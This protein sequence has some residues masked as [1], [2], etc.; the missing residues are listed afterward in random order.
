[1]LTRGREIR[2]KFLLDEPV[3]KQ[4]VQLHLLHRRLRELLLHPPHSHE[5]RIVNLLES[6]FLVNKL[7]LALVP[8]H[9]QL[10]A[11]AKYSSSK[12]IGG[13]GCN[14]RVFL[15]IGEFFTAK[16]SEATVTG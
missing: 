2:K 15:K 6:F 3:G 5:F 13:G 1:M 8:L 10:R 16:A 12:E 7:T 11:R 14:A 4:L 9:H